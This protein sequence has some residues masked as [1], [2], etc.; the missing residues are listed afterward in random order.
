MQDQSKL[1]ELSGLERHE[2]LSAYFD[3]ELEDSMRA[4]VE[5]ELERDEEL[6][7]GLADLSFM[8][9]MVVGD[10]EHQAERVPEARFEQIWD[11][12]E[13]TLERESR[14][15]EAAE[16]PPT[17]W[18]RLI[19]WA[20]PLRIP[21]A[22]VSAAGVLV[23][24][25]ARS[26]GAPSEQEDAAVASN[27]QDEAASEAEPNTRAPDSARVAKTAPSPEPDRVAL[28][29]EP[30]P[31]VD[32]EMFPQPEPGEAEIRRIEFGGQTG[33]ISQVE[34]ARGTTTVI[35]VTED[36]GPADSERSL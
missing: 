24:V 20:R 8:R 11:S 9:E 36:E 27:T 5:A 7:A 2:Q 28:A 29:P 23:F 22:A 3:D 19:A 12:F 17:V 26:A 21:I 4:L 16:Q 18:E 14:L 30:S 32:P 6:A 35:W 34:G 31:Q 10:L 15:Q 25:F 33:T 1:S 13:Q